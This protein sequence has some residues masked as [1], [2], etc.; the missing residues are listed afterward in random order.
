[1]LFSSCAAVTVMVRFTEFEMSC[2]ENETEVGLTVTS[3]LLLES[4]TE[5]EFAPNTAPEAI[6]T[7]KVS[8][9]PSETVMDEAETITL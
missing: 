5:A 1:M 8:D 4:V 3:L 9:P 2:F 6:S 7:V